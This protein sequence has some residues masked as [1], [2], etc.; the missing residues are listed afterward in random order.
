MNAW[1]RKGQPDLYDYGSSGLIPQS[2]WMPR[3]DEGGYR[4]EW[5]DVWAGERLEKQEE[6]H[7]EIDRC[8]KFMDIIIVLYMHVI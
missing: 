8:L 7:E 1:N 5:G 6:G 4:L 3:D 2:Y